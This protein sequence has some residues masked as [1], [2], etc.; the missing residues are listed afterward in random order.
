MEAEILCVLYC[1]ASSAK[2]ACK[3]NQSNS[4]YYQAMQSSCNPHAIFMQSLSSLSAIYQQSYF[5]SILSAKSAKNSGFW[6]VCGSSIKKC[7]IFNTW[8]QK[9]V[10]FSRLL[11]ET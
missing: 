6:K 7:E 5:H 9:A 10:I 1:A 8:E 11:Y 2:F 4:F 3:I